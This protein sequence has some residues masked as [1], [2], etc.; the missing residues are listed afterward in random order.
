M[1][2]THKG[3]K[4]KLIWHCMTI[5]HF[6]TGTILSN[7]LSFTVEKLLRGRIPLSTALIYFHKYKNVLLGTSKIFVD[8][9]E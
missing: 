9:I 2:L 8:I 1:L 5:Q 7:M 6:I 3:T 4:V